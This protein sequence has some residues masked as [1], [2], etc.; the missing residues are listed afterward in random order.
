[1]VRLV[2]Q[3]VPLVG[4]PRAEARDSRERAEARDRRERAETRERREQLWKGPKPTVKTFLERKNSGSPGARRASRWSAVGG[5][6]SSE[7]EALL[8][9]TS[10]PDFRL[11]LQ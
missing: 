8:P 7:K 5:T 11:I 10:P 2:R 3:P 1:M 6:I 9:I 4:Q